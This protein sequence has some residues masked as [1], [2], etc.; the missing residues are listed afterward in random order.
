MEEINLNE[1]FNYFLSKIVYIILF[2]IL[3]LVVGLFY[4]EFFQTP[5][6]KSSTTIVLA[7][8]WES[9]DST[10]ITSND[11]ILNQKL[12]ATYREII[13]SRRIL[14]KV[15]DNLEL[16]VESEDLMN[17]ITVTNVN[18]T[19]LLSISV[20]TESAKDSAAIANEIAKV[21]EKEIVDIY[22]IENVSIIDEAKVMTNAYNISP[23]KTTALG[24]IV[25]LVLSCMVIFV[26]F[27]FDT[28][29]KNSTTI[30]EKIGLP[31]LGIVPASKSQDAKKSDV[32]MVVIK[33]DKKT[34]SRTTIKRGVK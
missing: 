25:C 19:E 34:T 27:Y 15:V 30:E 9:T 17:S 4:T 13:K 1:L 29:I 18:E 12:V 22:N 14:D 32:P 5:L 21:F 26:M 11:V 8:T 20:S 16:D 7:R 6:Y 31:V 33:E 24:G 23:L 10:G 2:T 3:G 28:T